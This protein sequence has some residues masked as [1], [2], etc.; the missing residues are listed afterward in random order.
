MLQTLK[1]NNIMKT[2]T[3]TKKIDL[4]AKVDPII[5][6]DAIKNARFIIKNDSFAVDEVYLMEAK[7]TSRKQSIAGTTDYKDHSRDN[8]RKFRAF[9]EKRVSDPDYY[10]QNGHFYKN[11]VIFN[12]CLCVGTVGGLS[13]YP[14]WE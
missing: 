7:L 10:S 12:A 1:T 2:Q 13:V 5:L 3:E 4:Y 8:E 6:L 14:I 9:V 11:G